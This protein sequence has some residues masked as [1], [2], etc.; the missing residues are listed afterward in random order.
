M[1][2]IPK[3]IYKAIMS[4][5]T[6]LGDNPALPPE[7]E[8]KFLVSL[9]SSRFTEMTEDLEIVSVDE[10]RRHLSELIVYCR[11]LERKYRNEL[12][13]LCIDIVTDTINIP[14]DCI[15]F[16]VSLVDKVDTSKERML[17]ESTPEYSFDDME[18]MRKLT[19]EVYK[20]RMV[21]SMVAGAA[22]FY[23]FDIRQYISELYKINPELVLLYYKILKYNNILLYLDDDSMQANGG[24]VDAG[25]VD[26][27]VSGE[28]ERVRIKAQALIFPVLLEEVYKGLFE[29]AA[30]HGLPDEKEKAEYVMKKSDFK[31]CQVW[32]MRIGL[33][34]WEKII[35]MTDAQINPN[36]FIMELS[37]LP[38]DEFN[39]NMQEI[40]QGTKKGLHII[41]EILSKIEHNMEKD[42]FDDYM[43]TRNGEIRLDDGYF[44]AEELELD[45][46][47]STGMSVDSKT[48]GGGTPN[49]IEVG[50]AGAVPSLT[51]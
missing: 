12:E 47:E 31:L 35:N 1:A 21:N 44:T 45:E 3:H 8:E 46:T 32:D 14:D 4:D 19:K 17:P 42:D 26:V 10:F 20:R 50:D 39:D 2:S 22:M 38:V 49:S 41:D 23:G 29:L 27:I 15:I 37:M 28:K 34:L 40:L 16:D 5:K 25:N 9:L 6:S 11:K 7:E 43:T 30:L 36:F 51:V 18:D 48:V 13:K 33:P 24:A